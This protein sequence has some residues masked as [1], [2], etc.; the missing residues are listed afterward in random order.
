[1]KP[2]WLQR[3]YE[4][5]APWRLKQS[6]GPMEHIEREGRSLVILLN[7]LPPPS[8]EHVGR[9]RVGR[10]E[11]LRKLDLSLIGDIGNLLD[12][13]P[14]NFQ[15][16]VLEIHGVSRHFVSKLL[17]RISSLQ[18]TTLRTTIKAAL[19]ERRRANRVLELARKDPQE[20]APITTVKEI[21]N[22][23]GMERPTVLK[24]IRRGIIK[25]TTN[26]DGGRGRQQITVSM[27]ESRRLRALHRCSLGYVSAASFL[28]C[29]VKYLRLFVLL[30]ELPVTQYTPHWGAWFFRVKH[31]TRLVSRLKAL[32]LPKDLASN[33]L[34]PLTSAKPG[35]LKGSPTPVWTSY[36]RA[37]FGGQV[38][39]YH[40]DGGLKGCASLAVQIS[41]LP[42]S[43]RN[44]RRLPPGNPIG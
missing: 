4:I 3:L 9:R 18:L 44:R 17:L 15:R 39:L 28:N 34:T 38:R 35:M 23:T 36:A 29:P 31:L 41:D 12:E 20:V 14:M 10:N 21:V 33:P 42:I 24:A 1:V 5:F 22:I 32:A 26:S 13:W 43:Q 27:A 11:S 19:Q 30:G 6:F 7:F 37:I 2:I 25:C 40:M 8:G 16:R